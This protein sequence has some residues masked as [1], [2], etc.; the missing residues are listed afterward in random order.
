VYSHLH[1]GQDK[2]SDIKKIIFGKT[3]PLPYYVVK[4]GKAKSNSRI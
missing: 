2:N 4:D 3:R 1:F